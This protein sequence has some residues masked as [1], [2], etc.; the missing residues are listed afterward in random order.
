[1]L[2]G[3]AL[4]V[5]NAQY[6]KKEHRL[7]NAVNDAVDFTDKLI[8]LGFD[9][10]KVTNAKRDDLDR[11]I[12]DFRSKLPAYKVGLFYF[13]GH[14]LQIEGK[15]YLTSVDS[16]F[17]DESSLK[18]SAHCL[19]QVIEYMNN[20]S[21]TI[22]VLILDACRDNPLPKVFRGLNDPG[23]APIYAPQGTIIAFSTSPGEKAMDYGSGRN[24]IYTGSLLNHLD[25]HNI[26]IEEFFKRVRTSVY[27]LSNGKQTSWE[28]TSLIGSY[29]FNS[30]QMIHSIDLPYTEDCIADSNFKP[31]KSN[32]DTVIEDLKSHNWYKQRPA[33]R[34]L[35]GIEAS[36]FSKSKQ[37]LLGRNILQVACG[38]EGDT[39]A[40]MSRLS[41]WLSKYTVKGQ[42]HVL[43]GILFE[44][45]FDSEGKFRTEDFK[46]DFIDNIFDLQDE[47]E[48]QG[49]FTF[50]ESHLQFFKDYLYYIPSPHPMALPIELQFKKKKSKDNDGPLYDITSIKYEEGELLHYA[51]HD[52]FYQT[53]TYGKFLEKLSKLLTVPLK[54]L[55]VSSN[56]KLNK[57][58]MIR[59][60]WELKLSKSSPTEAVD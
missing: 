18:W 52:E 60:P 46:N 56:I 26:P 59:H 7:V 14:G 20:G 37:F 6:S 55:R 16:S 43:N 25:D 41:N 45:Y 31:D 33:I 32:V 1:M 47:P 27:T 10:M 36:E 22:K 44:I 11:N 19:D 34:K 30:G 39:L 13:S 38:G 28:H 21:T 9:V 15:N 8:R 58:D 57:V 12:I 5:G 3:L 50:I 23:L 51:I 42:N 4:V 24:S 54:L 53:S 2:N 29:S 17:I 48:F 49:S 35:R 40:I